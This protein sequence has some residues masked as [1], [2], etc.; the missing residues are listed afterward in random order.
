MRNWALYLA[1]IAFV[2]A[3][4]GFGGLVGESSGIARTLAVLLGTLAVFLAG[5]SLRRRRS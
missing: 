5:L 3:V 2:P 4:L 1:A